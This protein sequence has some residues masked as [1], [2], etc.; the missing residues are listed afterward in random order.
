MDYL[1][2]RRAFHSFGPFHND[3]CPHGLNITPPRRKWLVE[4]KEDGEVGA[5]FDSLR[6]PKWL[7]ERQLYKH[8]L[9]T[10]VVCSTGMVKLTLYLC[11]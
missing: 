7:A 3:M 6:K 4:L 1:L 11:L 10:V 9:E 5:K 2:L 8:V